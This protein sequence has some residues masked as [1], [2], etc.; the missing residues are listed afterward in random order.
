MGGRQSSAGRAGRVGGSGHQSWLWLQP[1]L[2]SQ[3]GLCCRSCK[4]TASQW[5]LSLR[6][7]IRS[8]AP[9]SYGFIC[10]DSSTIGA[11]VCTCH[12]WVKETA[13]SWVR[14]SWLLCVIWMLEDEAHPPCPS[15]GFKATLSK[16]QEA[17]GEELVQGSPGVIHMFSKYLL[18]TYSGPG[19]DLGTG[20]TARSTNGGKSLLWEYWLSSGGDGQWEKT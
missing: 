17:D 10:H 2:L 14:Q 12:L 11:T 18:C 20:D 1:P 3:A 7:P 8:S 19:S 15:E 16:W 6:V 9:A 5:G 13:P 4:V